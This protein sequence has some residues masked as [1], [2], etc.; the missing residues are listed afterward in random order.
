MARSACRVLRACKVRYC[1][2]PQIVAMTTMN[3]GEDS[4]CVNSC[5][6]LSGVAKSKIYFF[7]GVYRFHV[8]GP[9]CCSVRICLSACS[10]DW[11]ICLSWDYLPHLSFSEFFLDLITVFHLLKPIPFTAIIGYKLDIISRYICI[12]SFNASNV[13]LPVT[14]TAV[15]TCLLVGKCLWLETIL[16][17]YFCLAWMDM[18]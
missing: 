10:I 2:E 15:W 17:E 5:E 11:L 9:Y 3:F 8:Y 12:Y 16:D 14:G 6:L 4:V 18:R 1:L 13:S 7:G